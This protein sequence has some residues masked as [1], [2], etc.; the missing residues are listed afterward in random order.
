M[1]VEKSFENNLETLL[2]DTGLSEKETRIYHVLLEKGTMAAPEIVKISGLKKGITYNILYKLAKDEL[3][4]QFS[5]E[6]KL[7]FQP[8][9]PEK[10]KSLIEKR[11]RAIDDVAQRIDS[12][13]PQLKSM[14]KLSVGKP[15]IQ[16]FEGVDGL[17][18]ILNHVYSTN[19]KHIWGCIDLE[20]AENNLTDYIIPH[21]MPKRIKNKIWA[22]SIS[23]GSKAAEILATKD[24]KH[25]REQILVDRSTYPLPAEIEIYGDNV[26]ML[27]FNKNDFI[28]I[29]INNKDFAE[30]LRSI[31]K[32][33]LDLNRSK[34]GINNIHHNAR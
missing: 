3:V 22:H 19:D 7:Y 16:Y 26:A 34:G 17:K 30:S 31:C 13:L 6:G 2:L 25:L 12:T 29:I 23:A 28:G 24:K 1:T 10:L 20:H 18:N 15:T 5:R 27:S 14:Y 8:N 32:L 11:K 4:I 9:D 21:L 33:C